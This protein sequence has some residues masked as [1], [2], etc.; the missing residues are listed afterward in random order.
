M[1]LAVILLVI[2]G[3]F[4][5]CGIVF[6]QQPLDLAGDAAAQARW[7]TL[8]EARYGPLAHLWAILGCFSLR[9]SPVLQ[10]L[11]ACLV[12]STA[13]C[14]INRL[15]ALRRLWARPQMVHSEPFFRCL[16]HSVEMPAVPLPQTRAALSQILS[17]HRYR[18]AWREGPGGLGLYACRN[19]LGALGTHI[20]HWSLVL[21]VIGLAWPGLRGWRET[22]T[23]GPGQGQS[24]IHLPGTKIRLDG[25]TIDRLPDGTPQRYRAK[26]AVQE[27]GMTVVQEI[28][29]NRPLVVGQVGYYL[30]SYGPALRVVVQ[31]SHGEMLAL[32][33]GDAVSQEAILLFQDETQPQELS[34]PSVNATFQI[35]YFYYS[36]AAEAGPTVA[37]RAVKEGRTAATISRRLSGAVRFDWQ[38]MVLTFSPAEYAVITAVYDPSFKVIVFAALGFLV[39]IILTF[40]LP[41]WRLWALFTSDGRLFLGGL[42]ES[43][44]PAFSR[45]F[46]ML[47]GALEQSIGGSCGRP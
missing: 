31:G 30:S 45:H 33:S 38:D 27:A 6:P 10:L 18:L 11:L 19:R 26:L 22:I 41:C 21:L 28:G 20:T 42:A 37:I 35:Y 9:T 17:G 32:K 5:L 47:I 46:A 23:L 29:L 39:G 2:T 24:L 40:Y 43:N 25:L 15:K 4:A 1:R 12:L 7:W 8:A 16:E 3:A 44:R 34:I 13:I 14:S 36:A